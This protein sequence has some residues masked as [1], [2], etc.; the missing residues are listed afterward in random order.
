MWLKTPSQITLLDYLVAEA[1]KQTHIS[2]A[3]Y[4]RALQITP[5]YSRAKARRLFILKGKSKDHVYRPQT[6]ETL[7]ETPTQKKPVLPNSILYLTTGAIK[8]LYSFL[9]FYRPETTL[10]QK[11]EFRENSHA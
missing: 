4:F 11:P 9:Y 8:F 6:I 3:G 1:S 5:E 7:M 2:Q 10:K